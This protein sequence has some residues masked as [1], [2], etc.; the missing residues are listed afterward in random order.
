MNGGQELMK[1]LYSIGHSTRTLEFFVGLLLGY[2][3]KRLVDIRTMPRSRFNPQFNID[4]LGANLEGVSIA[5]THMPGLGGLRRPQKESPNRGWKNA[6]FRGY[7]DYMQTPEFATHLDWL[8]KMGRKE[9]VA[10]MCAEA[11]PWRCHRSLVSDALLVRGVLVRHIMSRVSA[12]A[13]VR[14]PWSRA[15]G[16]GL[17]YPPSQTEL[18]F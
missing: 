5:Y 16:T 13:H 18:A 8:I 1:P 6:S 9:S 4:G 14:T 17:V 7:A 12:P 11:V 2:Q 3:I 15:D 10:F